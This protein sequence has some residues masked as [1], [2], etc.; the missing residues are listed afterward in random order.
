MGVG[1]CCYV[2]ER[3]PLSVPSSLG[4]LVES[5]FRDSVVRRDPHSFSSPLP[6]VFPS[7]VDKCAV[8]G[9]C[10]FLSLSLRFDLG[11]GASLARTRRLE[12]QGPFLETRLAHG[13][14]H[15]TRESWKTPFFTLKRLK[16]ALNF[17][18]KYLY[19]LSFA[20]IA[21]LE[22]KRNLKN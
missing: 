4:T 11:M 21:L 10:C 20:Y 19:I 9:G 14:R 6:S 18:E 3:M 22:A 5:T 2:G 15:K 16:K 7:L 1:W 8:G 17:L 13:S 12:A